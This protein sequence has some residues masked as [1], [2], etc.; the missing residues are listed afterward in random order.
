M[1]P[2]LLICVHGYPPAASAGAELRAART[3]TLLSR[4][5]MGVRA[6]AF[7]SFGAGPFRRD[8]AVQ[9]GVTVR[10]LSGDPAMG[11]DAFEASYDS[12]AVGQ[13]LLSLIGEWRPHL[14]YLF[15]GYL[16]SSSVVRAA[17][18]AGIPVAVNLTDC[19]WLC[20]RVN[21][22]L[23]S[24][25]RCTGPSIA[26]CA[27]CL[28]EARR[29]W[30]LPAAACPALARAFWGAAPRVPLVRRGLGVDLRIPGL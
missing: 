1:T 10:R 12:R 21:L 13:E 15:S 28:A 24:G 23:P 16:M 4:R 2:R 11:Q 29:R 17:R 7:D 8:D 22:T 5:G 14:V 6:L 19:W 9:D 26:G 20:H 25:A 27:R 18:S 3:A 30:R